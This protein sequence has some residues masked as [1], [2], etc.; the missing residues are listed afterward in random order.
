[1]SYLNIDEVESALSALA[2][3]YPAVTELITLPNTTYE[4]RTSHALRIGVD[5]LHDGVLF[6]ACAHAREWGGAEI[7]VY[8]AADLLEAYTNGTGLTY[9]GTVFSAYTIKAIV[10]RLSVFVFP[11]VNPDGRKY[12]Q[13]NDALWRKN[14][15]A[16]ESG[17]VGVDL[18]RN[19]PW[20]WDFRTAFAP[21]AMS[22]GTLASDDPANDLYHGSAAGSEP[23][24]KN[25]RWLL[26][27]YPY[28]S[29]Y[30]D[31]HSFAGDLLFSWGDDS[32]QTIDATMNFRNHAYDGQRGVQGGYQEYIAPADL[33]MVQGIASRVVNAIN[34]VRGQAYVAK[35][36]VFLWGG[37]SVGY[38][39]SGTV[40]DYAYSRH[41][42]SC[43]DGKVLAFTL[44]FG[45]DQGDFRTSFHPPWPQMQQIVADA[46]AGLVE[47]CSAALPV[48]V[49]PW[50]IAW[51]RLFPW[52][53]YGPLANGIQQIVQGVAQTFGAGT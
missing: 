17:G 14:R 39:T 33:N 50:V 23:E 40:D 4:G 35:Q 5:S 24:G 9:G 13:D 41:L 11:C 12:D 19:H 48:W 18:N 45:F 38:P 49:P 26:D 25:I 44:E 27:T 16:T 8:F 7:C 1:M 2:S 34:N 31:I 36:S 6:T 30:M 29:R 52:E 42:A 43:V 15:N 53:I 21:G 3:T 28:I 32:D 37:T 20:L 51:R 10:E 46:D 47:F 22:F